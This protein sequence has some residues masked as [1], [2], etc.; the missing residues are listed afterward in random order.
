MAYEK[1]ADPANIDGC[2]D[3]VDRLIMRDSI[4]EDFEFEPI[5]FQ[6]LV[7]DLDVS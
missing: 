5:N 2:E 6:A 7:P 1:N 3:F 4:D